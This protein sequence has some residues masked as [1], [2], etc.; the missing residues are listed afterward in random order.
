MIGLNCLFM[1]FLIYNI[2]II[3]FYSQP[4][5]YWIRIRNNKVVNNKLAHHKIKASKGEKN[6][7]LLV[8]G[9]TELAR[10]LIKS[11]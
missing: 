2:F 8:N 10:T 9:V 4:S 6:P 11:H 7:R 1:K 5:Y 3:S